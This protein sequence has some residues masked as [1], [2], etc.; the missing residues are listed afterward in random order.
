M[1]QISD[2]IDFRKLRRY[3]PAVFCSG[4][5]LL[6]LGAAGAEERGG[7]VNH[8]PTQTAARP[9]SGPEQIH[10]VEEQIASAEAVLKEV[11]EMSERTRQEKDAVKMTCLDDKSTQMN[12]SLKGA[13]E[14]LELL[15]SAI[16]S[17]DSVSQNQQF[18]ILKTYFS[19]IEGLK[20]ESENC[21]GEAD[22][23]LG[24]T[25]TELAILEEMPASDPSEE[26]IT[27]TLGLEQPTHMSAYY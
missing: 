18:I 25:M 3:R 20:S 16:D 10:W 4:L 11:R 5:A 19:K 12:M 13:K 6:G 23:V 9:M 8:P 24:K 26:Q 21:L 17:K 1:C 2:R 7:A 27:D 14:R 15:R 22:V